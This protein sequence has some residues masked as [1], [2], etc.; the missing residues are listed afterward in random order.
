M[1]HYDRGIARNILLEKR[2][3]GFGPHTAD[4]AG[5]AALENGDG[6]PLKERSLRQSDA[7][8]EE[9]KAKTEQWRANYG[10]KM[11]LPKHSPFGLV[12]FHMRLRV[13]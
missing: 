11:D 9:I 12:A 4:A 5:R 1:L 8:H 3:N 2:N 13:I 6:F 7:A 10:A